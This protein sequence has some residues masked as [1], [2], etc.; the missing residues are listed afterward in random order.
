MIAVLG[1]PRQ[2]AVALTAVVVLLLTAAGVRR[3]HSNVV[4]HTTSFL[5]QA[6]GR[7]RNSGNRLHA[8]LFAKR[9]QQQE[10]GLELAREMPEPPPAT[11]SAPAAN[12][13]GN[14]SVLLAEMG[15]AMKM[16]ASPA[17]GVLVGV[18]NAMYVNHPLFMNWWCSLQFVG[19]AS[20][21]AVGAVDDPAVPLLRKLGAHPVPMAAALEAWKAEALARFD[22]TGPLP[23][24]V[25]S[26]VAKSKPML[27]LAAVNAGLAI[28]LLDADIVFFHNPLEYS[29]GMVGRADGLCQRAQA[30][31]EICCS[32]FMYFKPT[33]ATVNSIWHW[34]GIMEQLLL[35]DCHLYEWCILPD[36]HMWYS[37]VE[38]GIPFGGA[39][40]PPLP[41]L[42]RLPTVVAPD[43]DMKRPRIVRAPLEHVGLPS[44][45]IMGRLQNKGW[46]HMP[47][48]IKLPLVA[49]HVAGGD[50][51]WNEQNEGKMQALIA[52]RAMFVEYTDARWQCSAVIPPYNMSGLVW[53]ERCEWVPGCKRCVWCA[54]AASRNRHLFYMAL[55]TAAMCESKDIPAERQ[56]NHCPLPP[57]P[58]HLIY[59]WTGVQPRGKRMRGRVRNRR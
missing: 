11:V 29:A 31:T 48:K 55:A 16:R 5:R 33:A 54:G 52:H 19:A 51:P 14:F 49:L 25:W 44:V 26:F 3:Y 7:L 27:V 17:G 39:N 34:V 37:H 2:V 10:Q 15:A 9:P 1:P 46:H 53:D 8:T 18:A 57:I 36:Q 47:S 43:Q 21:T 45:P 23:G 4:G 22:V 28:L 30:G 12:T 35:V 59:A 24:S 32:G 38:M 50:S 58:Q 40:R 20:H 6:G 56:S 41:Q 42:Q 13:S